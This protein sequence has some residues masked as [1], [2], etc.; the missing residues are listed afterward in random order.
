MLGWRLAIVLAGAWLALPAGAS[1]ASGVPVVLL[2]ALLGFSRLSPH[3]TKRRGLALGAASGVVAFAL[4]V[5]ATETWA[6]AAFALSVLGGLELAVGERDLRAPVGLAVG[7]GVLLPVVLGAALATADLA[8]PLAAGRAG[9]PP[10]PT[11]ALP[12]AAARALS[13]YAVL[14]A[15]SRVAI[16]VASFALAALAAR[17]AYVVGLARLD[18][19]LFWP[20]APMLV[21]ALKLAAGEVLYGAKADL[22]SYSYAP[23]LDVTHR[24]LLRPF[25]LEL[26]L[27]AHRVLVFLAQALAAGVLLAASRPWLRRLGRAGAAAAVL[28]VILACFSNLL[29]PTVHPDHALLVCFAVA[30]ALVL[31][32]DRLPRP[33]RD[34]LLVLLTPVAVGFKLSGGGLGV[35]LVAI[36]LRRRRFRDLA[37]LAV[38]AVLSLATLPLFDRL[39][40]AYSFYAIT[41]Q[42][43]HP[44][45]LAHLTRPEWWPFG[46]ALV[47]ASVAVVVSRRARA[48]TRPAEDALVLTLV[49]A[50]ASFPAAA[51]Y[52]GRENNG[53]V[54][55][56]GAVVVLVLLAA[57]AGAHAAAVL[58]TTAW[59]L[60][61][62][63]PVRVA[64]SASMR[65]DVHADTE[66]MADV[67]R[68]DARAGERTLLLTSVLP[69]IRAGR[70]DVPRDRWHSAIEL[71]FGRH[72]EGALLP[73]RIAA[74]RYRSVVA[75]GNELHALAGPA[76]GFQRAVAAALASR[77]DEVP[78]DRARARVYARRA[79]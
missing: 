64:P 9:L 51:K 37:L 34:A 16:A 25:G 29:A 66:R 77:Y 39:F 27:H 11:S 38:S 13:L 48:T 44:L 76:E 71:W 28:L 8:D 33:V 56:V 31:A 1:A 6:P 22:D 57:E 32:D 58:A 45:E 14:R 26:D 4:A 5:T 65:A 55:L 40:G 41:L 19:E 50:V 54:V 70:R 62:A 72:P 63:A 2:V 61:A 75:S 35:A 23:L 18:S 60:V 59:L 68:E 24:A 10:D 78:S 15:S 47:I 52:A 49:M 69:W 12:L 7:L 30:M 43:S 46:A 42:R 3:L 53:A 21:N 67:V 74:G 79:P 17:L 20:E 73:E 36:A